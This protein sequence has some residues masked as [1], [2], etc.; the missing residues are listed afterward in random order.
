MKQNKYFSPAR[1]ARLFRNDL[2]INQKMYFFTLIGLS[3]AIY[4]LS[5]FTM[6][7]NKSYSNNDYSA[8]FVVYLM[9]IG[10]IVGTAFPAFSNS[11]KT[12]HYLLLPGSSVEKL[13]IQFFIRIVIFVPLALIIFWTVTHLAKA[14]M[15]PDVAAGFNPAKNIKDFQFA[16]LFNQLDQGHEKL[17]YGVT[18]FSIS[19]ILFAGSAFFNRFALVKTLIVS[20]ITCFA[21]FCSFVLFSH[22][23]YPE[24][25]HG[26]NVHWNYY[27]VDGESLNNHTVLGYVIGGLSW[28]FFLPLAYFKLKEKEV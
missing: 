23:F 21:V 13:L 18:L 25:V 19:T 8:L 11:I 4:A 10:V 16:M 27:L 3:L 20:A 24:A 22:I 9:A 2:M 28:L 7:T 6:A 15:I 12:N 1:F 5:Y 26:F 14:S 17:M